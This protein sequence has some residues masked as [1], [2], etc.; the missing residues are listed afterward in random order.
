ML[1]FSTPREPMEN[2]QGFVYILT[3]PNTECIKIG[4]TDYPPAKRIKEINQSE[5]YKSLGPWSLADFR[6]VQDWRKVEYSIHYSLRSHLNLEI[7][8]QKELF[9]IS[10][11]EASEILN[12][13]DPEQIVNKPKVDR[14]FQ[15]DLLLDYVT[16]LFIFTGLMNWLNIQGSW[17]FALFPSTS[18]GR[19]FTINLGPHEVAFS[20]I[21]KRDQKQVNMVLVDR[22]VLDFG[23]VIN[24]IS[25]HNGSITV[26]HYVTALPRSTSL[27][28]EGD[29]NDALEFYSLDGVRRALIA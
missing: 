4:G 12:S 9:R 21:G 3:S 6:Q 26:D 8:R 1:A 2:A 13:I 16:K 15:D 25:A 20:T 22:L 24:W 19:Y 29:F 7:D 23:E 27:V 5:P 11:H 28:F 17:T 18:G 14:L 10:V